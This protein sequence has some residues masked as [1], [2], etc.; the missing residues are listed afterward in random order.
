MK[1]APPDPVRAK[2]RCCMRMHMHMQLC[3]DPWAPTITSCMGAC[4]RACVQDGEA[5]AESPTQAPQVLPAREAEMK[6]PALVPAW[7]PACTL[8]R[9]PACVCWYIAAVGGAAS[10][11]RVSRSGSASNPVYDRAQPAQWG[12]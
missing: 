7:V 3:M 10:R 9:M 4:V 5:P 12:G 2:R 6:A 1:S 11:R 8:T